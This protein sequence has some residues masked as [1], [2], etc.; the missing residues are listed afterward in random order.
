MASTAVLSTTSGTEGA[1]SKTYDALIIG[2]GI[3]GIYQLYRLLGLG[4]DVRTLEA[5]GGVGGVWYWNG[6]PGCRFDSES[7]TYG[8]LFDED[9]YQEW[10]WKEHYAGQPEIE[11]HL[12]H[13]VDRYG[14]RDKIQFDT[15][16]TA[17]TFDEKTD[18]WLVTTEAGETLRA[19]FLLTAVGLLSHPIYP[20]EPGLEDFEGPVHHTS[21]WPKEKV[22]FKGKRVAVIG[23]GASGVQLI[24]IVAQEAAELTIFQRT[25]NWCSPLNNGLVTPDEQAEL[26]KLG[27]KGVRARLENSR[28][29]LP[30]DAHPLSVFDVDDETRR[31]HFESLYSGSGLGIWMSNYVDVTTDLEAN[32]VMCDFVS[33]KIRQRVK[34]PRIAEKL[35]PDHGFGMKRP[36]QETGYYEVY[37]QDNVTLVSL[38]EEPIEMFT[39]NG[40]KTSEREFEFDVIVLATGFDFGTGAF[41]AIDFT[42]VGGAKLKDYWIDGPLTQAGLLSTGFPNLL[43]VGGV[44]SATGNMPRTSEILADLATDIIGNARRIR[45]TRIEADPAAES[46]WTKHVYAR[47]DGYLVSKADNYFVGQN[48]PGKPRRMLIYLSSSLASFREELRVAVGEKLSRVKFS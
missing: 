4:L 1:A 21:R 39:K 28:G 23:T 38:P 33:E 7:Y 48:M 37:N 6:Y 14:L 44:H 30:H 31:A 25:P 15:R 29:G 32:K 43:M 17:A 9:L 3:T 19:R 12:N 22:D 8:F 18:T 11:A 16:V 10:D 34:D 42:G 2:A 45:A 35:I 24:P 13:A 41:F 47:A 46:E 36:P 27:T 40:I 5:G 20:R 26:K